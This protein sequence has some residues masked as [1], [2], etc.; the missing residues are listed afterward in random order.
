MGGYMLGGGGGLLCARSVRAGRS[1]SR[2]LRSLREPSIW[3]TQVPI[4]ICGPTAR[5]ERSEPLAVVAQPAGGM[6]WPTSQLREANASGRVH[7]CFVGCRRLLMPPAL[8]SPVN[9]L[10]SFPLRFGAL[11]S[12]NRSWP[13]WSRR[14]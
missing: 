11:I 7:V 8:S 4:S 2:T 13:A 10:E 12:T 1:H 5:M 3:R 6:F 9:P 14:M